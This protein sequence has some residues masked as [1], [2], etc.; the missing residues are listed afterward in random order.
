MKVTEDALQAKAQQ[1]RDLQRADLI[2]IKYVDFNKDLVQM[3][4]R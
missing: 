1:A 2:I 4:Q 3:I